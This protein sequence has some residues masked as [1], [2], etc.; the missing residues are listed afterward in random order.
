MSTKYL[1]CFM[2]VP[3]LFRIPDLYKHFCKYDR[4]ARRSLQCTVKLRRVFHFSPIIE[5]EG[6]FRALVRDDVWRVPSG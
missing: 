6:L 5:I 4:E 1:G 3:E 2:I